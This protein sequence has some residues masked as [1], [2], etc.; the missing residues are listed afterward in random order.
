MF[1]KSLGISKPTSNWLDQIL[2]KTIFQGAKHEYN[3]PNS[4]NLAHEA[5][6]VRECILAG[7]LESPLLPLDETIIIAEIMEDVRKQAGVVYNEDWASKQAN[8]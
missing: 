2:S 6:H 8:K 5:Q 4:N 7:K 1:C 3:F